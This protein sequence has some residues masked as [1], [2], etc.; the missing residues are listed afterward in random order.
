VKDETGELVNRKV[1]KVLDD[2]QD[3]FH[4]KCPMKW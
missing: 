2:H 4:G 3:S 1:E